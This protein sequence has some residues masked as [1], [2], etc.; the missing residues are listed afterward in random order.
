MKTVKEKAKA[1]DKALESAI[2]AYKDEDRHLKATLERIFPELKESEDER[3][4]KEIINYFKCQSIEE[5]SRKDTHNKWIAWLEKVIIPNHNDI[6][7]SFIEDIKNVISEAP[8]LMQSD[9][10]KMIDWLE[11]QSGQKPVLFETPKTPVKDTTEVSSKMQYIDDDLKPI[12]DF[13]ID[14]AGW[15]LHKEEW[16]CPTLT[17]P[18]FRVLDALIQRGKPYTEG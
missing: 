7:S 6:D 9:K 17:V 14:Y 12:A 15:N 2:I 10:K 11:N 13:I 1:Y 18:L 16:S 8:L 3:I 4:S 5:P